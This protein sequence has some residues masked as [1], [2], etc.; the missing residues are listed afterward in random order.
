MFMVEQT[1]DINAISLGVI[2]IMYPLLHRRMH[3]LFDVML[4]KRTVHRQNWGGLWIMLQNQGMI[5]KK[6][7]C[8]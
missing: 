5:S 3:I 2:V 8:S 7:D 1:V 4:R 6:R